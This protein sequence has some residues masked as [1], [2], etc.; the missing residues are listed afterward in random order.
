[1]Q[2]LQFLELVLWSLWSTTL[3]LGKPF[4]KYIYFVKLQYDMPQKKKKKKQEQEGISH[5]IEFDP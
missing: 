2:D 1:M 4:L 5:E 3:L